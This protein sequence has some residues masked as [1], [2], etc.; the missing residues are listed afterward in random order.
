VLTIYVGCVLAGTILGAFLIPVVL[1]PFL[2]PASFW[3]R[4]RY[5]RIIKVPALSPM[6]E[7]WCELLYGKYSNP[8]PRA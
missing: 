3:E 2:S 5:E 4:H 1:R 6:L 8:D 7:R